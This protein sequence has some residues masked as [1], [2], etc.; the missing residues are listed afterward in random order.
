M[1]PIPIF[2][3]SYNR[4]TVLRESIRSFYENIGQDFRLIIHDNASTFPPLLEYLRELEQQGIEV[5]HHPVNP[6]LAGLAAAVAGTISAWMA[7]ND[8]DYY[9][10]TDP[11]I[12]LDGTFPNIL[13]FYAWMLDNLEEVNV[14]GPMLRID[15]LPDCY[16]WKTAVIREHT[17]QFWGRLPNTIRWKRNNYHVL[18]APIDTSFGMY[19]AGFPFERLNMGLRTYAPYVARHLDWY[20]DQDRPTEDQ[21]YYSR[22][23]SFDIAHWGHNIERDGVR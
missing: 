7:R 9:V 18:P 1:K 14:V 22:T 5:V 21:V 4:L 17:R 13:E 11:D 20:I 23:V 2:I 12:A 8:A 10:V 19:R 15:D 16:R 3:I 6:P